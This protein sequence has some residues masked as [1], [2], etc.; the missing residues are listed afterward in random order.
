M[1]F[2]VTGVNGQLGYDV[3]REILRRG[4]E[5][6]GSDITPG[7]AGIKPFKEMEYCRC[8]I[9]DST[10]LYKTLK[11]INP[12]VVVHCAAW[13]A[14]DAAE[15]ETNREK[16][17]SVNAIGTKNIAVC[18][19][20]LDCKLIYISTDYVFNGEGEEPWAADCKEY[21]P[22][23][24]YGASKLQGELEIAAL[25]T[26]FFIVRISWVFGEN[27]NNFVKTMLNVAKKY[28]TV[29]VVHDQI[30]TPTYTYDLAKLLLDMAITDR[31][32]YYHASN[33]GGYI[34]WC[35]FCCEIYRLAGCKTNIV[36]VTTA[37]YGLTKAKRPFNSRLDKSKLRQNSFQELPHWKDALER[38]LKTL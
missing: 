10:A 8:D 7:Y 24:V 20:E 6:V 34:S 35:E 9:T 1:K 22:L 15:D 16:V 27:G 30:G 36:P 18:W 29:R 38:Y 32:G 13:T 5:G 4:Y 11:A 3:M 21:A 23:N 28:D 31:Y 14:V 33:A 25:L 17:F 12:D 19:K 2:F 26:K 37:E